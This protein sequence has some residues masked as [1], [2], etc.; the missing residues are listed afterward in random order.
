GE[1]DYPLGGGLQDQFRKRFVVDGARKDQSSHHR[2]ECGNRLLLAI[3]R[4][5]QSGYDIERALQCFREGLANG[6]GL[7][8]DVGAKS[9]NHTTMAGRVTMRR[10]EI[11]LDYASKGRLS[12]LILSRSLPGA[13]R[14]S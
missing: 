13:L 2:C 1:I 9:S 4:R 3:L 14:A 5:H 11:S 8:G 6:L 7:A 10:R 12:L